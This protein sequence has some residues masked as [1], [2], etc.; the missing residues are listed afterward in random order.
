MY[1]DKVN[2]ELFVEVWGL[3]CLRRGLQHNGLHCERDKVRYCT[4]HC[5]LVQLEE[6]EEEGGRGGG[7][8][9][10]EKEEGRRGEKRRRKGGRRG[11][12]KR[13]VG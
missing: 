4:M 2:I 8:R 13:G 10:G 12:R 11:K 1:S 9:G 5:L 3:F 7:G 6:E